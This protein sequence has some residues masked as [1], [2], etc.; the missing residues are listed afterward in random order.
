MH[1]ND[2]IAR[3][4]KLT[5]ESGVSTIVEAAVTRRACHPRA[6]A[7]LLGLSGIDGSGKGYVAGQVVSALSARRLKTAAI[8]A[9]GWLNLPAVRFDPN[10]P[11]ENS[12]GQ[13]S[14]RIEAAQLWAESPACLMMVSYPSLPSIEPGKMIPRAVA[15][16][17]YGDFA[18]LAPLNLEAQSKSRPGCRPRASSAAA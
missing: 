18:A 4:E 13:G 6:M 3:G 14:H 7:L 9:D 8:N 1:S 15:S 5:T 10:R 2:A 17:R 16:L 11:G 12:L